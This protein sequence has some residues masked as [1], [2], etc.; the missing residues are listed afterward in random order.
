M[1]KDSPSAVVMR[2]KSS[3]SR[4]ATAE[5]RATGLGKSSSTSSLLRGGRVSTPTQGSR[6]TSRT[7]MDLPA[8]SPFDP[9]RPGSSS[10]PGTPSGGNGKSSRPGTPGGKAALP[11]I[12]NCTSQ[13]ITLSKR[14]QLQVHEVKYV[15]VSLLK[16]KTADNGGLDKSAF[17]GFLKKVFDVEAVDQKILEG[18]YA[19]S[20]CEH[21]PLS[22][23]EFL[24]WYKVNMFSGVAAA[25]ADVDRSASDSLVKKAAKLYNLREDVMDDI[26]RKFDE[27]DLDK[28]G[29]IEYSEFEQMIRKLLGVKNNADLPKV[30][31]E[32]FWNEIDS[33]GSGEVDFIEFTEWYLKYFSN[34]N[35]HGGVLESFYASYSPDVQRQ[36]VLTKQAE[37]QKALEDAANPISPSQDANTSVKR[38][39]ALQRRSTIT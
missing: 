3:L 11:E 37:K 15:L 21:G 9:K 16:A 17:E 27:F 7:K 31:M 34:K 38:M 23:D 39:P 20:G 13:A 19:S 30:R 5:P 32:R 18:A 26:K 8:L 28:S 22:I 25:M 33:D 35:P 1:N 36:S 29:A 10:N 12:V 24:S 4:F 6:R 14:H 2:K